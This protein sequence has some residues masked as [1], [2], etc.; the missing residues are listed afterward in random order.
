[1][2]RSSKRPASVTQ[3]YWYDERHL[4]WHA[5]EL[6]HPNESGS[7]YK[8]K[9]MDTQSIMNYIPNRYMWV[10]PMMIDNFEDEPNKVFTTPQ[11]E[12]YKSIHAYKY[13]IKLHYNI[14]HQFF[15]R[16]VDNITNRPVHI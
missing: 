7:Q 14:E 1:M 16:I 4:V 10:E 8:V 5:V 9:M 6:F 11:L 13:T 3:N 15:G 12:Y 2:L